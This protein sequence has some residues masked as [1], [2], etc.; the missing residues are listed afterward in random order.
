MNDLSLHV[1]GL[2]PTVVLQEA[3]RQRTLAGERTLE[4]VGVHTGEHAS[5]TMGPATAGGV[6]FRR[7][8]LSGSPEIP[9]DL[10]HVVAC[11]MGTSLGAGEAR[12]QTVEHVM[13][14]LYAGG[15][16]HAV[17][18]LRGPEAPILDGSFQRYLEAVSDVGTVELEAPA[19]V[20]SVRRRLTVTMPGGSSYVVTPADAL[21]VS[22]TIDFE[23]QS[24]GRQHSTFSMSEEAFRREIAP[25]RTFGFHHDAEA[26]RARGL[27]QGTSLKNTIVLDDEG[28]MNESLRFDDEFVRHK[29]GDLIGDLALIGRRVRG[30]I[31]SECPSHKGNIKLART[32]LTHAQTTSHDLPIE[33]ERIMEHLPHRYPFLLVDR[34]LEFEPEKR[35]VGLKNVTI[36]EPY[37]QGHFPGHPVMPGVLIIEAMAQAGGLLMMDSVAEPEGKVVYFMSLDNVKWRKPVIPGDQLVFEVEMVQ[38]RRN[39]CKLRGVAKVEGIM[40]AEADMM[41]G[42]VD[43]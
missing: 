36:S 40:A 1:E 26:L 39:V 42:I 21:R 34:V 4:G 12:V 30:N 5:L 28:I 7:V 38:F 37:F 6:R 17:L 3:S 23:H 9:A 41:A 16:D 25:A 35:I 18:E 27:A 20:I 31:V 29:I 14:A 13:A 15:V 22:A 8:D 10:D 2:R 33:V 11:E 24:I 32:L 19:R 43:R